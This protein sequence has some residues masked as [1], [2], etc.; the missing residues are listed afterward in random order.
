MA[1]LE[2]GRLCSM[3]EYAAAYKE[4]DA[5][6]QGNLT[7]EQLYVLIMRL[8]NNCN[9]YIGTVRVGSVGALKFGVLPVEVTFLTPQ[10]KEGH[11]FEGEVFDGVWNSTDATTAFNNVELLD[12]VFRS[13]D[14]D[15]GSGDLKTKTGVT[16]LH[17]V[18]LTGI[19]H[20]DHEPVLV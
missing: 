9:G 6:L 2:S 8:Q 4:R 19:R 15:G 1:S 3:D 12:G 10:G 5:I 14:G 20:Y 17:T 18:D 16:R 11:T 7:A 13:V